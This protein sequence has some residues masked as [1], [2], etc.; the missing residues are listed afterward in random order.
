VTQNQDEIRFHN[1]LG[2][3]RAYENQ[4]AR[5]L[6]TNKPPQLK[7]SLT[8]KGLASAIRGRTLIDHRSNPDLY[9]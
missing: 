5:E 9:K 8:R 3:Y 7:E 2:I 1:E 4:M 6:G